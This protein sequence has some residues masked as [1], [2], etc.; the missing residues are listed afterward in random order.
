M[1]AKSCIELLSSNYP[2]FGEQYAHFLELY[3][4]RLW[5]QL[6]VALLEFTQQEENYV[7]D[8]MITL[9]AG[10]IANCEQRIDPLEYAMLVC[11][12]SR[13]YYPD[14]LNTLEFI[15]TIGDVGE[16]KTVYRNYVGKHEGVTSSE[17]QKMTRRDKIGESAFS[18]YVLEVAWLYVKLG[19]TDMA[20]EYLDEVKALLDHQSVPPSRLYSVYYRVSMELFRTM[21]DVDRIYSASIKWLAYTPLASMTVEEKKIIVRDMLKCALLSQ[22]V[23]SFG[24]ILTP[25]IREVAAMGGYTWLYS[26]LMI[27]NKGEVAKWNEAK[28]L[29]RSL[30][31]EDESFQGK[32]DVVN[33]KVALLALLELVFHRPTTERVLSFTE[34]ANCC[35]IQKDMIEYF[36]IRGASLGLFQCQINQIEEK[37]VFTWLQPRILDAEQISTMMTMLKNWGCSIHDTLLYVTKAATEN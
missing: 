9:Y 7:N 21:N 29:Y 25:E 11:Y 10:F 14:Y 20:Q 1:N 34:I 30:M 37:V 18:R 8:N 3:D 2:Q 32:M 26:L 22:E 23:Y 35:Q 6:T 36:L 17:K 15:K 28:E 24:E 13:Q 12:I 19:Q 5:Y 31:Q 4:K 33:E 27:V 16:A